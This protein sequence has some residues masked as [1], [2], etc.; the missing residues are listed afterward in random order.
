MGL[1]SRPGGAAQGVSMPSTHVSLHYHLVFSTKERVPT[2]ADAFKAR[3]H[4]YLGGIVG[5]M[6]G[7]PL[8]IGG[9]ADHVH[10]LVG[11]KATHC[12]ADVLRVIKADSSKWIHQADAR[13]AWQEGY[14]AFTVS[15]SN[16][17]AVR[18]YIQT[19]EDHH[20]TR[21]FRDEY[22]EFLVK[23]DVE[24]DERYLW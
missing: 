12:L 6:G 4:G 10:M 19:Q 11:L 7:V 14:G 1:K 3:L 22:R 21:S 18:E 5:G 2:I 23:H 15:R 13:F 16:L 20:R 9:V 17:A 8:E 24:F